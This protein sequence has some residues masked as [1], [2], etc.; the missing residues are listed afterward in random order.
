MS[1]VP[2]TLGP[3]VVNNTNLTAMLTEL[4]A[5][6]GGGGGG[7]GNALAYS[8]SSG[9]VDPG[10]GLAGFQAGLGTSGTGRLKVTLSGNTTFAGL[11]AGVDGQRLFIL[12][13]AG[14]F[15]L[16]LT[17]NGS[18]AGAKMFGEASPTLPLN[19]CIQ[20]FYD[21]GLAEWVIAP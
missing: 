8:P 14:A 13:V 6:L 16:T 9:N 3:E 1:Q 19:D 5:G 2:I 12:V 7:S 11:P 18:T 21:S 10:A 4:Y 20:L 17:V 15:Q